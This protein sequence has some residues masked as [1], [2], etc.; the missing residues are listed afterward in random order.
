MTKKSSEFVSDFAGM[1][2]M[3]VESGQSV[4]IKSNGKEHKR[5]I[6]RQIDQWLFV[7][8][9]ENEPNNC[10]LFELEKG[11]MMK[12]IAPFLMLFSLAALAENLPIIH[13]NNEPAGDFFIHQY[14]KAGDSTIKR[15]I[16][17]FDSETQTIDY[18]TYPPRD[19]QW[20]AYLELT[21]AEKIEL[22]EEDFEQNKTHRQIGLGVS[23]NCEQQIIDVQVPKSQ[24]YGLLTQSKTLMS[25]SGGAPKVSKLLRSLADLFDKNEEVKGELDALREIVKAAKLA[26]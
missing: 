1:F 9:P 13:L 2:S 6:S 12:L 11:K 18:L 16:I 4:L 17:A 25:A 23:Q 21:D 22:L 19:V 15:S 8:H 26:E 3:A 20:D 5:V 14:I 7:L 10:R 24:L